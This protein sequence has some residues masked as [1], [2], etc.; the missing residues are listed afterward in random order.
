[1]SGPPLRATYR[2]QFRNGITFAHAAEAAPRLAAAG[3]SHLY[4][5]PIFRAV[6]GSTHGYDVADHNAFEPSLGGEAGFRAMSA[7]LR[8][9]GLGLILDIVPNH[10]AAHPDNP[11]W[12]DVLRLGPASP[13]ARHFDIDWGAEKL[14]LPVLGRHY[15]DALAAGDIQRVVKDDHTTVLQIPGQELPL[16]PGT[17]DIADVNTCHEAQH[18]RLAH[19]R[20]AR[21]GLTYR[22]FFEIAGL[23]GVRVEDPAVFDDVH[24]LT[25]RLIEDGHVCGLRVDHV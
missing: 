16:S 11:W 13:Y 24:R 12:R 22:R 15:G 17:E 7:A 25:V 9:N 18:Y 1:M 4:A 2:L 20:I 21:D 19:W 14:V 6:G 8:A 10:M 5:S 23:V 3:I